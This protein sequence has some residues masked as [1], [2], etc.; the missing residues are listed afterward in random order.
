MTEDELTP[1]RYRFALLRYIHKIAALR[2]IF[3]TARILLSKCDFKL[4]YRSVHFRAELAL[5]RCIITKGLGGLDLAL[6]YLHT[7][8][9]GSP[10]PSIFSE[11]SKTVTNLTNAIICCSDYNPA[12]FPSHYSH[13]LGLAKAEPNNVPLAAAY[14]LMVDPE[15]DKFGI[16]DVFLDNIFSAVPQL[17]GDS[18]G[19]RSAQAALLALDVLGQPL[20]PDGGESLLETKSSP[21]TRQLAERLVVLGW[22]IDTQRLLISLPANIFSA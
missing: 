21:L 18:P 16:T 12:S 10:C 7:T 3:P 15:A 17:D 20:L 5:Q 2:A 1:C 13:L 22:M 4:A 8:F 14:S 11:I 6:V 19:D 9:D